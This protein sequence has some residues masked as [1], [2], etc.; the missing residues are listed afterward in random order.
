MSKFNDVLL[1]T[2]RR[3][4]FVRDICGI[5]DAEVS[6]KKGLSGLTKAA[7]KTVKAV[8][9]NMLESVLDVLFEE[10]V[11]ALTLIYDAYERDPENDLFVYFTGRSGQVADALLSITDRRAQKSK[12]KGLVKRTKSS[13]HRAQNTFLNRSPD[14]HAFFNPMDSERI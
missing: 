10:F 11:E 3:S 9:P 12:L 1:D 14:Y 2:T 5:V 8:K 6:D 4:E 7:F 13:V